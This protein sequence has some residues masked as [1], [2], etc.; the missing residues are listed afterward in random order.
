MSL[1]PLLSAPVIAGG[2]TLYPGR[3]MHQVVFGG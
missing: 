2:F 3:I 1:T